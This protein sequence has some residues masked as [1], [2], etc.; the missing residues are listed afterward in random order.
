MIDQLDVQVTMAIRDIRKA[1]WEAKQRLGLPRG[2][3]ESYIR[4]L[5]VNGDE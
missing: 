2:T 4:M 1:T 5:E 3:R